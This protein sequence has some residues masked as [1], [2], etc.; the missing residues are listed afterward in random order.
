MQT[1]TRS[2]EV[3]KLS[4]QKRDRRQTRSDLTSRRNLTDLNKRFKI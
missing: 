3:W 4:Y 1:K 2:S